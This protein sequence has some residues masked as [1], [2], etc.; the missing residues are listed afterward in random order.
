MALQA[1]F[2]KHQIRHCFLLVSIVLTGADLKYLLILYILCW[3]I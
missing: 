2:I 1:S 3:E